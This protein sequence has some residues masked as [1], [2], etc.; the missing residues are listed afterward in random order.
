[1]SLYVCLWPCGFAGREWVLHR[2]HG[3]AR[4][5]QASNISSAQLPCLSTIETRC[6]DPICPMSKLQESLTINP[7]VSI[8]SGLFKCQASPFLSPDTNTSSTHPQ[9]SHWDKPQMP[10]LP[11][12]QRYPLLPPHANISSAQ[13]SSISLPI[14]IMMPTIAFL[15]MSRLF[16]NSIISSFTLH[17]SFIL[18]SF[19]ITS[20]FHI[21]DACQGVFR[22]DSKCK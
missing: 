20:S 9:A 13:I 2:V 8:S 5:T 11:K 22:T 19:S 16:L 4:Y 3:W 7:N 18:R 1:M 6:E 12:P 17:F 21:Q 10:T 14:Y 15:N